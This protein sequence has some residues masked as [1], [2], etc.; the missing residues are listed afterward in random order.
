M[1]SSTIDGAAANTIQISFA[2]GATNWRLDGVSV[3]TDI[4][5]SVSEFSQLFDQWRL[6]DI[7]LRIDVP[8]GASNSIATPIVYPQIFYVSDYD[9][10]QNAGLADLYQYPQVQ[11]HNFNKNGYTPL[12]FK[13]SPKPLMDVAGSGI[14]TTY[15]PMPKAPWIRS[16]DLTTPHY[17]VK[18]AFDW[19]GL[20]QT[21]D[22]RMAFTIWYDLEFTNPR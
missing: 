17:G 19:F 1:D 3:Y 8:N 10:V 16:S 9:D 21:V 11:L 22:I 4:L 18:M 20:V 13:L 2:P 15:G 14:S 7:M 12:M 5:Q 6:K